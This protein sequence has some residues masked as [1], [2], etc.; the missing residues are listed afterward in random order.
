MQRTRRALLG[1]LTALPA[2]CSRAWAQSI[3]SPAQLFRKEPEP[4]TSASQV[5]NVMDF[6]P[7][8]RDA[9]PP[10]HFAYI[11]TGVDDDRTVVH[12][13]DAYSHYEIRVRRFNDISR[14]DTTTRV[15]GNQWPSPLYLSAVSAQG[16]FHA[17]AELHRHIDFARSSARCARRAD[18]A[19][20]LPNERLER[21]GC[22]RQAR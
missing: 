5:L 6:E 18:L 21:R 11:A 1:A 19:T 3:T 15:F 7:L 9:L 22:G 17:D 4:I 12:N 10:A 8:A 20:A 14:L 16:A 2:I 13:H